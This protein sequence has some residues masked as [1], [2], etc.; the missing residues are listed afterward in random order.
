[1]GCESKDAAINAN[2]GGNA[3]ML[4]KMAALESELAE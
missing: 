4:V 2:S 3:M 1:L